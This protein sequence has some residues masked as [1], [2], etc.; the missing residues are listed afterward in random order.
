MWYWNCYKLCQSFTS[1]CK[2]RYQFN[3]HIWNALCTAAKRHWFIQ[4]IVVVCATCG[5]GF[6]WILTVVI[7]LNYISHYVFLFLLQLFHLAPSLAI[8]LKLFLGVWLYNTHI[9]NRVMQIHTEMN[10]VR[11]VTLLSRY[12]TFVHQMFSWFIILFDNAHVNMKCY[13]HYSVQYS[14]MY[15]YVYNFIVLIWLYWKD[16]PEK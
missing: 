11:C 8:W 14:N 2:Y 9:I 15:H 16:M 7:A 3:L 4:L 5:S 1:H 12:V 13:L 10:N 6:Q